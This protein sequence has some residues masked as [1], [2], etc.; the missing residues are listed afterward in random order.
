[1][2]WPRAGRELAEKYVWEKLEFFLRGGCIDGCRRLVA[3]SVLSCFALLLP[4][5]LGSCQGGTVDF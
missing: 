4:V 5:L 2:S 1:M 3:P